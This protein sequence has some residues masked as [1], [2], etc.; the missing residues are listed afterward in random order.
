MPALLPAYICLPYSA[1]RWLL[2]VQA[3]HYDKTMCPYGKQLPA[4]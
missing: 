1:S 4:R 2:G 3:L